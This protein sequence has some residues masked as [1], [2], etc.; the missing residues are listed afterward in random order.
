MLFPPSE[1]IQTFFMKKELVLGHQSNPIDR[2]YP[3]SNT[4]PF[5]PKAVQIPSRGGLKLWRGSSSENHPIVMSIWTQCGHYNSMIFTGRSPPQ[6]EPPTQRN[7]NNL[8]ERSLEGKDIILMMSYLS[9]ALPLRLGL[10]APS[11]IFLFPCF[12]FCSIVM[13]VE[14]RYLLCLPLGCQKN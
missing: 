9:N 13:Y 12:W 4:T 8:G 7:P 1:G 10:C 11:F 2:S 14:L 5:F 3:L 6:F